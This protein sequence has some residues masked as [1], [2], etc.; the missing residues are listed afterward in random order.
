[1]QIQQITFFFAFVQMAG[2]TYA[3]SPAPITPIKECS[4]PANYCC[5][6]YADAVASADGP[7]LYA[8]CSARRNLPV[9]KS[10]GKVINVFPKDGSRKYYHVVQDAGI[11]A[12]DD[13]ICTFSESHPARQWFFDGESLRC[14]LIG[15]HVDFELPAEANLFRVIERNGEQNT[16]LAQS[17]NDKFQRCGINMAD[18]EL[19]YWFNHLTRE[20]FVADPK[21]LTYTAVNFDD[22]TVRTGTIAEGLRLGLRSDYARPDIID[23]MTRWPETAPTNAI[24]DVVSDRTSFS[25]WDRL[26][27]AY[28]GAI[29]GDNSC[30]LMLSEYYDCEDAQIRDWVRNAI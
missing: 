17:L 10:V 28:I 23:F 4:V 9:G 8:M 24:S 13:I 3:T 12:G 26:Q 1:M 22:L 30:E 18:V 7:V 19:G 29:R 14:I 11:N 6:R 16:E 27:L 15:F 21:L 20:L 5:A 25:I 2:L